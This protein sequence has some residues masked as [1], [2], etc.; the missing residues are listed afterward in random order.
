MK[1]SQDREF[2]KDEYLDSLN[3]EQLLMLGNCSRDLNLYNKLL[4]LGFTEL[5]HKV[6]LLLEE[7]IKT[8]KSV[9]EMIASIRKLY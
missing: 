6:E 3:K 1:N 9:R 8:I 4:K 2:N 5:A 7:R